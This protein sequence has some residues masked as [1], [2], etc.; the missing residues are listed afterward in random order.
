M[1]YKCV[2]VAV[3]VKV[4][5]ASPISIAVAVAGD[6]VDTIKINVIFK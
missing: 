4:A 5:V 3:T 1:W 6:R 2:T